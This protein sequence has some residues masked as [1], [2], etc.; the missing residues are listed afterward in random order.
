MA[1]TLHYY[2]ISLSWTGNLG[3]GTPSY[4][5]YAREYDI[6]G[7]HGKF[8]KGSADPK[9][10][11]KKECWN[12]EELLIASLSACHQLWYLH[13]CAEAGVNVVQ[14]RDETKG[15]MN[16]KEGRFTEVTLQP[17]VTISKDSDKEIAISL[18]RLAHDKCYIANSVNIKIKINA[19]VE[20]TS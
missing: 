11:G 10:L 20:F 1:N 19:R 12:P 13:L 5:E 6:S 14:Y 2:G 7:E 16:E 18:H 9:F 4:R 3:Q 15:I 17:H 8:L